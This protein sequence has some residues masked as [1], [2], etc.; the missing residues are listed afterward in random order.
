MEY[1]HEGWDN[2]YPCDGCDAL[3]PKSP[4]C[5]LTCNLYTTWRDKEAGYS[6][7]IEHILLLLKEK[8]KSSVIIDILEGKR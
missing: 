3:W 4:P 5:V 7:A 2:L 1:R 6:A 8:A